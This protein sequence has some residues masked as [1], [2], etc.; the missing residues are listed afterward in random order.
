MKVFIG[1]GSNLD[2]RKENIQKAIE[3]LKSDPHVVV[4]QLSTFIETDSEGGPPQPKYLNG[5]I[6]IET[7]LSPRELLSVLQSIECRLG[8]V[9][10]VRNGP[11]TIDLDILLYGNIVV[12]EPGLQIPHP[13]MWKR[14]FVMKPLLEIAPYAEMEIKPLL[15]KI[16]SQ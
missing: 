13:R 15:K 7:G 8:R 11:R 2:N 3:Y 4:Q 10:A 1:V 12:E 5:V 16:N 14:T 9:R 6:Q